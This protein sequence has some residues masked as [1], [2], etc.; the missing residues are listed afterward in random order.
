MRNC[1]RSVRSVRNCLS[2]SKSPTVSS[3]GPGIPWRRNQS[4]FCNSVGQTR[5][6]GD[7]FGM[8]AMSGQSALSVALRVAP[9]N[10][11]GGRSEIGLRAL[12]VDAVGFAGIAD[13]SEDITGVVQH[14]VKDDVETEIV[15]G[16]DQRAKLIVGIVG[17]AGEAGI[18]VQKIVNA[19]S[20]IRARLKRTHS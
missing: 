4:F 12:R 6:S 15:S 8:L 13:V 2:E 11:A 3:S 5:A 10:G 7:G 19:V 14:D 9:L 20:V 18:D 17:I 1:W 16:I